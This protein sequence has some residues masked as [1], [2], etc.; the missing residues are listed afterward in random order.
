MRRKDREIN[1]RAEILKIIDDCTH[2]RIG[3]YDDGEIY[4]V[5]LNFGYIEKNGDLTLYFHSAKEGRKID[6]SKQ[7]PSVA[8]EM[9]IDYK[10]HT[11]EIPI[12]QSVACD[13]TAR[14]QSVIGN[15]KI[16]IVEEEAEKIVGLDA[17]MYQ[18]TRKKD[19]TYQNEMLMA[20]CVLKLE[21]SK[22]SCKVHE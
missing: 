17:I 11:G 5:P 1:D 10:L 8:F 14:F 21:V 4:I 6:L 16:S 18:S 22:M 12:E 7:S 13:Y 3:F 20:V 2:C 19:W 15:G 9:D